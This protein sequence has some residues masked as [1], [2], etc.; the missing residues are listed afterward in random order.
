M[1]DTTSDHLKQLQRARKALAVRFSLLDDKADDAVIDETIRS[2]VELRGAT[3]W[4]LIFAIFIASIGLNVNS[5]AVIIGAM[6]ISPLMGPIMGVGYGI[7]IYDFPLIR[8]SLLNLGIATLI[9]LLTSAFYFAI[10]PLSD[11][12]SELLSRTTPTIW[13]VLIAFFGGL[14]GVVGITR[15][16]KSNV[17]PGVAI[18]TALMPPLC[19]AGYGLASQNWAFFAGAFYLFAIN[20]VFIAFATVLIIGVLHPSH[21]QFVDPNV[22]NRVRRIL[23]ATV[24]L[25]LLPS[26]YL[27]IN[28]VQDEAFSSKARQ[29][30]KNEFHFEQT[31]V[32]TVQIEPSTRSIEVSLIGD[33][34]SRSTIGTIRDRL[35][36]QGLAGASI[37][38]H[39][40]GENRIDITSLKAGIVSDLYRDS[41]HALA[42]KDKEIEGLKEQLLT[43]SGLQIQ[44]HDIALELRAQYP[45]LNEILAGYGVSTEAE[46]GNGNQQQVYFLTAKSAVPLSQSEKKRIES[47]FQVRVKSQSI[48]L[49]LEAPDI[50]PAIRKRT[51]SRR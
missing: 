7:G 48:R 11:A 51:A 15:K 3:P 10:T 8:K 30:V 16:E 43:L 39:Q 6:L 31:H 28:L 13:D 14:A 12:Q 41:L 9:A 35:S 49:V 37:I 33:P 44:A 24:V 25:T 19:T 34:L 22:G 1:K 23:F 2:G 47:W 20:C 40:A 46:S 26:V 42:A 4:I 18:A 45:E 50:A 21:R 36:A 17:I 32:T 29:F 38:V 27:A 5:T